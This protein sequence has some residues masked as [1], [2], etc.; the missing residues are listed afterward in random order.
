MAHQPAI[1]PDPSSYDP[2]DEPRNA[3]ES[4]DPETQDP[5]R[6][7]AE[8]ARTLAQHGGGNS[9]ANLAVDLVLNEIVQQACLATTATG[10]AVALIDDGELIVRATTG[11]NA[12]E[13][14][15]RLSLRAGLSGACV[16][17]GNVQLCEDT[18]ADPRVDPATC[19]ELRIQSI[20]AVPVTHE[21]E[22]LGI[23]EIF[24]SRPHAFGDRDEQTL[25]ALSLRIVNTLRSS[26]TQEERTIP[27]ADEVA[28]EI[29]IETPVSATA[30]PVA[31]QTPLP[32]V[33]Q[34]AHPRRDYLT[35]IL[36]VL[37]IGASLLLGWMY[38]RPRW[39][40]SAPL[41]EQ[42]A[43][44][45]RSPQT[46]LPSQTVP[47]ENAGPPVKPPD[48]KLAS[49]TSETPPTPGL[50][51]YDKGKVI[52]QASAQKKSLPA[53]PKISSAIAGGLVVSKIGPDYPEQAQQQQIEG[54]VNLEITVGETGVVQNVTV[55][56]GDP[57]LATAAVAAVRQWRF[58]PYAPQG[59]PT[60][61]R[62]GVTVKFSL[63]GKEGEVRNP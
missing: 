59:Q 57:L 61:F 7:L 12:P 39:Q 40:A 14:G 22:V 2:P 50:V 18:Q 53:I 58:R 19:E 35:F 17:T 46:D 3:V 48:K 4:S 26:A 51:V 34:I 36:T 30:E 10:A 37:V 54:P 28:Q 42:P 63:S 25:Q 1:R 55:A 29:P 21:Y 6:V 24:S 20:L 5:S 62:T 23:L 32:A 13:L 45:A 16:Q 49:R 31:N 41:A 47:A 52:Y 56:S 15:V 60:P 33:A 38:G 43:S 9:S 27:T 44:T 11:V 8:L